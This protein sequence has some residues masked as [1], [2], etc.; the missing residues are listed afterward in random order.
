MLAQRQRE[1]LSNHLRQRQLEQQRQQQQQQQ[2]R[3][4]MMRAQGL[5]L[6]PNMAAAVAAPGSLPGTMSSPRIP[7]ANPQQ[8]PYPPN[9]GMNQQ[10]DAG[11]G[12]ATT[13]Q[14]PLMS[15]RMGH[16]QSPMMQQPQASASFQPSSEMNGWPQGNISGNSVFTQQSSPQFGQQSN[17][18]M[19]NNNMNINVS[20]TTNS[21]M[22]NMNQMSGQIS[23]TS[24]T[25]V[26]TSG[27]SSMGPEQ[28]N[29]PTMR[30]NLFPNQLPGMDMIKQEGEATRKYC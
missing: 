21:S 27:L 4:M 9:Y 5:S 30:G 14:S 26:P 25:S 8:F 22:N 19:Y 6:P 23:M 15:P 28:V 20:M 3:A 1:I 24:M 18:S 29:D 16:A 11:F 2:Q 13:P 7:Q 17:A 10:P 12:G